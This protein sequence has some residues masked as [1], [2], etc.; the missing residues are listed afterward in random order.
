[1]IRVEKAVAQFNLYK[2]NKII[3][4]VKISGAFIGVSGGM[5]KVGFKHVGLGRIRELITEMKKG[6]ISEKTF[7]EIQSGLIPPCHGA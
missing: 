2:D 6:E 1:M 4:I 5:R 7:R 3:L